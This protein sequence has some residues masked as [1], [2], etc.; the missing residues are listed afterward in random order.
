MIIKRFTS[1]FARAD[2]QIPPA[3]VGTWKGLASTYTFNSNGSYTNG[4]SLY[5]PFSCGISSIFTLGISGRNLK[6]G[7]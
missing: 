2:T 3:L 1:S 4:S 6:V 5:S 7:S